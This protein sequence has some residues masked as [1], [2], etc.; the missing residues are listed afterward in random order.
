M[1]PAR[2]MRNVRGALTRLCVTVAVPRPKKERLTPPHALFVHEPW[3]TILRATFVP[4]IQFSVSFFY[5][6]TAVIGLT[7]TPRTPSRINEVE[8][9]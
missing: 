1:P 5:I 9:T 6:I 7:M 4:H 2:I 8:L 3:T